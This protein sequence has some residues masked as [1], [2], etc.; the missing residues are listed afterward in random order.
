M[1]RPSLTF[2][3]GFM[4]HPSDWDDVRAALPEYDTRAI[5][6][7]PALDWRSSVRQLADS[8]PDRS[9]VVGYSMGARLAL[10]IALEHPQKCAGLCFV[11]GNP[12]LETTEARDKRWQSDQEIAQQLEQLD[13]ESL[14]LFLDQWYQ[15]DVFASLPQ[16]IRREQIARKRKLFSPNWPKILRTHSVSRQ[17]NYWPSLKQLSI[18]AAVVAGELDEK[19]RQIAVK[20]ADQTSSGQVSKTIVPN[21]GHIVHF[22]QPESLAQ[23]IREVLGKNQDR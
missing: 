12:G 20:F 7:K 10:G 3:H 6:I 16:E 13:S 14:E 19:Y 9:V 17:P 1:Q 8:I 5:E 2:I 15:A 4:G 23:T 22:E 18:P 11:S 21:C